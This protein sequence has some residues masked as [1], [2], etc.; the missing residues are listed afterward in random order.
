MQE[1]QQEA[2]VEALAAQVDAKENLKDSAEEAV[3]P[4]GYRMQ[5]KEKKVKAH[6]TR[7]QKLL[8]GQEKMQQV[9]M[10]KEF[11]D[12][13]NQ[14]EQR[15]PE[16]KA[17][18][19]L[20]LRSL[21]NPKDT[22]E[23]ILEKIKREFQDVSLIDEALDYLLETSDG[24]LYQTIKAL[25][26][27]FNEQNGREILAGRNIAE[28]AR[29]ASGKGLGTPTSLRD[30]YRD[31]TSNP[32]EANALFQELSS[33]YNF[34]DL[35]QALKF[36]FHALGA[37]MK[38]KGPSIP[39][40]EL[41]T[42]INETRSLQAILGVYRFFQGRMNLMQSLFNKEG[43]PMP[44]Q[45]TF[46]LMAKQFMT[47]VGER[48]P[49]SSKF[50]QSTERLGVEKWL[51]AKIIALS[52]FRDATK[53]VAMEKI[54]KSLQH[55]DEFFL[56]LLEALE[57]LEDELEALQEKEAREEEEEEEDDDDEEEE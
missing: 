21:I 33:K 24:E 19:L 46:E 15:N 13:A 12:K 41:H 28:E 43:I 31:L 11:E 55:R 54:Y 3:N 2:K 10:P 40:G 29:A 6:S 5:A 35:Q 18:K 49:S 32:R 23:E 38:A 14:F 30:Q 42:L 26:E 36:F 25:K 20:S 50:L 57:D 22:K 9:K 8:E 44:K 34:K 7:I 17:S 1:L 39:R 16:L 48:Y 37:D 47:L 27:E 53:S 45:L 56:A 4:F 51:Q 52:Q